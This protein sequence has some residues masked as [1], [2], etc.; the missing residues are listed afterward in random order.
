MPSST[1]KRSDP[2]TRRA[3]LLDAADAVFTT[4]GVNAPLELVV[5]HAGVGRA[6]LYRQFPDRHAILLA[7]L[8]RSAQRTQDRAQSLKD[9]PDAF[10]ALLE[11]Q[12]E[13]IVRS[14]AVSD[15]WRITSL[16]DPRFAPA[17]QQIRDAFAPTL[18]RAQAHGLVR[19]DVQIRDLSLLSGMLGAALRGP[20][21][22]ERRRLVRQ[23]LDI[24]RRGL[25]PETEADADTGTKLRAD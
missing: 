7:L 9:R 11:Y 5:Q 2:A 3:Q 21:D 18:A 13:R 20:T 8:E 22:A 15:Y 12:A 10:F 17:R 25:R 23:A 4:H 24:V 16:K 6:T 19:P 1:T 14:P